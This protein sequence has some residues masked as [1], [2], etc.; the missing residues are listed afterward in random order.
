MDCVLFQLRPQKIADSEMSSA[1]EDELKKNTAEQYAA[2]GRF[3]EAFEGM[4]NEVREACIERLCEAVGA[5]ERKRL[6]EI[7]FHH[8]N[9]TA[10]ILFD[11][12]RAMIAEIVSDQKSPHYADQAAFKKVL[13]CIEGEYNSLLGIRNALLHGTW[14]VGYASSDDPNAER[15]QVRK[16][17]TTANGLAVVEL[18]KNVKELEKLTRRCVDTLLW[19]GHVDIC[20]R[21]KN[22]IH[23]FFREEPRG[24]W[25]FYINTESSGTTLPKE[26]QP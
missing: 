14:F 18:P 10:K 25:K 12:M 19:I 5:S 23:D 2:L 15:F 24:I 8:Q 4:V 3:V 11:I 20:L 21:Y 1:N 9:M 7:P 13:S 22:R 17:K 16:Y 26:Q 6:I